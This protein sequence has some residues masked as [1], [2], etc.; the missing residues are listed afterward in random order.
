MSK[1]V[2]AGLDNIAEQLG[3]SRK[4]LYKWINSKDFPAFKMDGI[5]RV[6]PRDA[7]Q[8]LS[9]QRMAQTGSQSSCRMR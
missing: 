6:L 4:T 2:I 5:W 8:W 3:C 7:E 1:M 9:R